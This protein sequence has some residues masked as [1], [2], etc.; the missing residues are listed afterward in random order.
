[1]NSR[2]TLIPVSLSALLYVCATALTIR[3]S[4]EVG[5]SFKVEVSG[6]IMTIKP[7]KPWKTAG[8][9][10]VILR[11]GRHAAVSWYNVAEPLQ[12][13][14]IE[15]QHGSEKTRNVRPLITPPSAEGAGHR[16]TPDVEHVECIQS[17][18][19]VVLPSDLANDTNSL[20]LTGIYSTLKCFPTG[21]SVHFFAK[22]ECVT[23]VCL[24]FQLLRE[25]KCDT[26]CYTL[27]WFCSDRNL[28]KH[29]RSFLEK[30]ESDKNLTVTCTDTEDGSTGYP[31]NVV[32]TYRRFL[33]SHLEQ[34][35]KGRERP[36]VVGV[37]SDTIL[38]TKQLLT[39]HSCWGGKVC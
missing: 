14:N 3:H 23:E 26:L 28:L 13:Q 25:P 6:R 22:D 2:W 7:S 21:Y 34:R 24:Y 9:D 1:M 5:K 15:L 29:Y 37:W 12:E 20:K 39:S 31:A 10:Y 11:N 32:F 19:F 36:L 33:F 17:Q 4:R 18:L 35:L 27:D 16:W 30:W 8:G 38:A